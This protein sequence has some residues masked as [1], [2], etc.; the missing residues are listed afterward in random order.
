IRLWARRQTVVDDININH[1]NTEYLNDIAL[2]DTITATADPLVAVT[3]AEL[4]VVAV[5][6]QQARPTLAHVAEH[7]DPQAI[8]VSLIKGLE[9]TTQATM[10]QVFSQELDLP[11]EQFV[12]V[13][14]PNLAKEI[15]RE[16]PTAT[17]VA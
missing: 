9:Q 3:G 14:G 10:S 4:V 2:P 5:P 16:E 7:I 1:T 6:A 12:V 13:S 8:L 17:V 11:P 15:A